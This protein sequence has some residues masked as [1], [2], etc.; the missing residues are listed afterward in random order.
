MLKENGKRALETKNNFFLNPFGIVIPQR[1]ISEQ[2][3]IL[4][5]DKIIVAMVLV[6]KGRPMT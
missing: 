2:Y 6:E 5:I 1:I 3:R 4:P